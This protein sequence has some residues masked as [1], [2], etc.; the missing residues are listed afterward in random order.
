MDGQTRDASFS[1]TA[2]AG[3]LSGGRL[4]QHRWRARSVRDPGLSAAIVI[5][6]D[7]AD[8]GWPAI[9][10][11]TSSASFVMALVRAV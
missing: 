11:R 10:L 6:P 1:T 2:G 8:T 3:Q 7:R 4:L 5:A 9:R